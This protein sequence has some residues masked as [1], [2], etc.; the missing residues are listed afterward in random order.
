M[1]LKFIVFICIPFF[2]MYSLRKV[3]A[4][5]FDVF[6]LTLFIILTLDDFHSGI[7]S[8]EICFFPIY[9]IVFL[10]RI[11]KVTLSYFDIV[12]LNTDQESTQ[13]NAPTLQCVS[14][15]QT[16]GSRNFKFAATSLYPSFL[17][18]ET[19]L[20]FVDAGVSM[21]CYKFD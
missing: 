20:D 16:A 3:C 11:W 21:A 12:W 9:S 1:C 8:Q 19:S 6:V 17:A 4:E 14:I 10:G 7:I 15:E 13:H 18:P 2:F 5:N